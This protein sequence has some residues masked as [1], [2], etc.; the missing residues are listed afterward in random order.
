MCVQLTPRSLQRALRRPS[1]RSASFRHLVPR[2]SSIFLGPD[3]TTDT[4]R[5]AE[6]P[7]HARLPLQAAPGTYDDSSICS[8]RTPRTASIQQQQLLLFFVRLWQ[9]KPNQIRGASLPLP[10]PKHTGSSD[11]TSAGSSNQHQLGQADAKAVCRE[12]VDVT[13]GFAPRWRPDHHSFVS[14][15]S[16]GT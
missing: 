7:D 3:F 11:H 10:S 15:T 4:T 2:Q 13:S 12:A 1:S 5:F 16:T 9:T 6:P 8:T 14:D